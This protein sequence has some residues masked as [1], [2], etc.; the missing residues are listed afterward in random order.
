MIDKVVKIIKV[1]LWLIPVLLVFWLFDKNFA[2]RGIL[3]A[4]CDADKCSKLVAAFATKE[5]DKI[6]GVTKDGDRY[7]QINHDPIYFTI[8]TSRPFAKAKITAEFSNPDNQPVFNFGLQAANGAYV[9]KN[10]FSYNS[11]IEQLEKDWEVI[12]ENDSYLFTR[13]E[14]IEKQVLSI[15]NQEPNNKNEDIK[16][17]DKKPVKKYSSID[18]FANNLP[19]LDEVR[20]HNYDLSDHIRLKDY[21]PSDKRLE[22]NNTLRGPHEIITYIENEPLDF[23]FVFQDI[24]RHKGAD[25]FSIIVSRNGNKVLEKKVEDDGISKASGVVKNPKEADIYLEK[26]AF[27]VYAISIQAK[28][29]DIFIKKISTRQSLVVFKDH[30]YFADDNEY[31]VLDGVVS[32]SSDILYS[33]SIIS[34][35]TSHKSALQT[36]TVDKK[37]LTIKEV[38]KNYELKRSKTQLGLLPIAVPKSDVY[39]STDGFFIFD[40]RQF[41]NPDLGAVLNLGADV[42]ENINY[43][44]AQYPKLTDFGDGWLKVEAEFSGKELYRDNKGQYNFILQIPG[45]PENKRFLKLRKIEVEFAKEPITIFNLWTK[46]KTKYKL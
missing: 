19:P 3:S 13:P 37:S 33:G 32:R 22:I 20:A 18:E 1:V 21:K 16:K 36:M 34:A 46:V 38:N 31:K 23:K 14:E 6:I 27:G 43:V 26:P 39:L 2:P 5:T 29:D 41:F 12:K 7:R 35:R 40:S 25:N 24:N 30:L 15:K 44:V 45:L 42:P 8:K 10:V 17:V 11:L 4:K 9:F 28:D